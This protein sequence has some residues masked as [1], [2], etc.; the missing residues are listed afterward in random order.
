MEGEEDD[1]RK[2]WGVVPPLYS[3]AEEEEIRV[4]LCNITGNI[5]SRHGDEVTDF[6]R[7]LSRLSSIFYN[8]EHHIHPGKR[9]IL[10][11]QV[12]C[13]EMT[14]IR[15]AICM[16]RDHLGEPDWDPEF[17]SSVTA[18]L[19]IERKVD[20]SRMNDVLDFLRKIGSVCDQEVERLAPHSILPAVKRSKNAT[21]PVFGQ[22]KNAVAECWIAHGGKIK[23]DSGP[24]SYRGSYHEF[25]DLCVRPISKRPDL[26]LPHKVI[27]TNAVFKN[28]VEDWREFNSDA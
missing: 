4:C 22:L 24:D 26:S 1:G 2:F 9:Y 13:Q 10:E 20:L 25:F 28:H 16:L 3:D 21:K 15:N 7:F 18:R 11:N 27:C 12:V 14:D 17:T 23:Y 19:W 5:I 8:P 6:W